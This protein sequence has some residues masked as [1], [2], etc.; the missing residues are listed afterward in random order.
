MGGTGP[1]LIVEMLAN[2]NLNTDLEL[3][4]NTGIIVVGDFSFIFADDSPHDI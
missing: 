2:V 1:D 3:I 4:N